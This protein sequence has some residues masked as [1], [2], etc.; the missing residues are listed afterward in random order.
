MLLSPIR[1]ACCRGIPVIAL[2]AAASFVQAQAQ[3]QGT[4]A[5]R[6]ERADPLDA[7]ARVPAATHSSA[8]SSYRRLGDDKRIDWKEANE[9]VNRIGGWRAYAREAQQP[10]PAANGTGQPSPHGTACAAPRQLR[11]PCRRTAATSKH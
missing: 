7:R 11:A 8:L 5:A 1:L 6:T 9:A 10:E 4:R 3:A 2:L